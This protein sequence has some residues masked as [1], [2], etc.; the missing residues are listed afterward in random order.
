MGKYIGTSLYMSQDQQYHWLLIHDKFDKDIKISPTKIWSA[1]GTSYALKCTRPLVQR[2]KAKYV[3]RQ[4]STMSI[5][6]FGFS[7]FYV[8]L[9]FWHKNKKR[10]IKNNNVKTLKQKKTTK[11]ISTQTST[12]HT[13]KHRHKKKNIG[14]INA[15]TCCNTYAWVPIFTHTSYAFGVISL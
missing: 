15:W 7:T 9:D 5:N 2:Y 14:S 8:F 3:L 11:Q 1:W 6:L 13:T 4:N 12:K 10:L